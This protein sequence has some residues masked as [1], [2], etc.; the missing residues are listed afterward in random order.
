MKEDG[1]GR[2]FLRHL[3]MS[4][5]WAITFL[6]VLFIAGAG[7][8]Q[9]VKE[10]LQY[11]VRTGFYEAASFAHSYNTIV[12][13]KKNVKEGVEFIA[14]TAGREIKNLLSDP[15]FKQDLKEALEFAGKKLN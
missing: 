3:V 9:Q 13:V 7:L 6:V 11:S 1:L 2:V 15:E 8:K 4:I 10:G 12:P 14:K 5:P